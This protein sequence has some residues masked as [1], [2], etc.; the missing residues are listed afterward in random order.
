VDCRNILFSCN[1]QLD[2]SAFK[3]TYKSITGRTA[4]KTIS[5]SV[6]LLAFVALFLVSCGY[7]NPYVYN[8]PERVIFLKDWQNRTSELGLDNDIYQ[9][10][11][12]W[13]QKSGSIVITKQK[14]GADLILAGEIVSIDLPTLSYGSSNDATE[15]KVRLTTRYVMK[16][17]ASDAIVLEQPGETWT[18]DYLVGDSAETNR[19]NRERALEIIVEDLAQKIYQRALVELPR[20]EANSQS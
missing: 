15:V 17:L 7:H 12:R 1:P 20:L 19:S 3:Q 8:G 18:Q 5:R 11:V 2:H 9:A 14:N 13:F 6:P 16:D 4:L 10:L